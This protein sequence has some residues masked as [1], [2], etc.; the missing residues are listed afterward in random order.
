M[1]KIKTIQITSDAFFWLKSGEEMLDPDNIKEAEEFKA[2]F[3]NFVFISN[4]EP[5]MGTDMVEVKV[6]VAERKKIAGR[7]IFEF[8]ILPNKKSSVRV[9]DLK[10]G[11]EERNQIQDLEPI[12]DA[13]WVEY[14]YHN[15]SHCRDLLP[16]CKINEYE[17]CFGKS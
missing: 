7:F 4:P 6:S 2:L 3:G 16:V 15:T 10:T 5:I 1:I 13:Y 8:I 11:Y 9:F 17:N 12:G 14:R